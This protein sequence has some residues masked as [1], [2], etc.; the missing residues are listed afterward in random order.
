MHIA[1]YQGQTTPED[2]IL[3]SKK[4]LVTSV[5]CYNFQK[6]WFYTFFFTILYMYIAQGQGLTTTLV[7]KFWCQQEHLVT[8][9]IC[10]KFKKKSLWSRF[11]TIVHD[12]IHVYSPGEEADSPQGTTFWCQQ[13]CFVTSF[14]CCKFHKN[15]FE[16]W[17]YTFLYHY[18]IHVNSPGA[19]AD[20]PQGT[21]FCCQQKGFITLPICCK[22]QR[23]FFEVWFYTIFFFHYFIHVYSPG[24]GADNPLGTW[25]QNFDVNRNNVILV[26]CCKF[27]KHL[28]EVWFYTYFSLYIASGQGTY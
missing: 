27:Q 23:N 21:K 20:I 5:I 22:F 4:H 19:G 24:A 3:M 17:F 6:L 26:I 13:K 8:S 28:F 12:L 10:C 1:A 15:V 11:Y 9:V 25:G 16:V 2:K 18:L 14:S 7:T